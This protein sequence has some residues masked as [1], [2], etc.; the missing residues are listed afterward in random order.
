MVNWLVEEVSL[1]FRRK[2]FT[3]QRYQSDSGEISFTILSGTRP[4]T[5]GDTFSFLAGAN[6][7]S[8]DRI[9]NN[10]GQIESIQIP[11]SQ[12]HLNTQ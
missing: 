6:L 12:E 7:L 1:G 2:V 10:S 9:T 4:E 3:N 8:F 5:D 11:Y